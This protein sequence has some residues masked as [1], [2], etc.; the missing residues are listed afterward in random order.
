MATRRRFWSTR[1]LLA[2]PV[3]VGIPMAMLLM[4]KSVFSH[5]VYIFSGAYSISWWAAT[6]I[7]AVVSFAGL[8][9]LEYAGIVA[10]IIFRRRWNQAALLGGL[11]ALVSFVI[12]I[13]WLWLDIREMPAIERYTW[14]GWYMVLIPGAYVVGTLAFLRDIYR[15]VTRLG[16]RKAAITPLSSERP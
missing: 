5:E 6:L 16:R 10:Q 15:F 14:S 13:C 2:L 4:L 12:G 9:V 1:L 11:T 8:P 3:A 7:L